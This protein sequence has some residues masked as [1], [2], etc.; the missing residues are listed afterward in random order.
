[1]IPKPNIRTKRNELIIGLKRLKD[2][3]S[4]EDKWTKNVNARNSE[5]E[6]RNTFEPDAC[7]WGLIGGIELIGR[8]L[9]IIYTL[10]CVLVDNLP[11]G[12]RSLEMFNDADE[13]TI[14]DVIG[15]IDKTI[16]AGSYQ[17]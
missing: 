9:S 15:V 11:D 3:F 6:E 10:Q 12:H 4:D 16:I 8:E 2:L 14:S 1:M 17:S 13:T 5:G 7:Q